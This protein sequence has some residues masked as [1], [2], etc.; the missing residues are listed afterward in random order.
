MRGLPEP[1]YIL[2]F[3]VFVKSVVFTRESLLGA[4]DVVPCQGAIVL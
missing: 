4:V 3:C 1:G 2:Y